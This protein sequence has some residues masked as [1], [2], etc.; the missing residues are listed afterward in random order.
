MYN[1]ETF[2]QALIYV[3]RFSQIGTRLVANQMITGY[4]MILFPDG[5]IPDDTQVPDDTPMPDDTLV[6]CI[7]QMILSC[8]IVPDTIWMVNGTSVI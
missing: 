4:Q 3:D 8:N 1:A 6:T 7:N 2:L 5:N